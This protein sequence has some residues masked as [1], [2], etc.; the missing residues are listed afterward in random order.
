MKCLSEYLE[1]YSKTKPESTF[2]VHK[3]GTYTYYQI[4][5]AVN[6]LC[7]LIQEL[8]VE[9][10]LS[11]GIFLTGSPEFVVALYSALRFRA[12]VIIF[13]PNLTYQELAKLLG[14]S[15][16]DIL[17]FNTD[18]LEKVEKASFLSKHNFGRIIF[19]TPGDARF[20]LQNMIS[21]ERDFSS[22]RNIDTENNS[23]TIFTKKQK[24]KRLGISY[25]QKN[26]ISAIEAFS[27][28]LRYLPDKIFINSYP[29]NTTKGCILILNTCLYTGGKLIISTT[30][31]TN[32][33]KKHLIKEKVSILITD[34]AYF[35]GLTEEIDFENDDLGS[36]ELVLINGTYPNIENFKRW[37]KTYGCV[38]LE[39][40]GIPETSEV[41]SWNLS[42][43]ER[44]PGSIGLPLGCNQVKI[45]DEYGAEVESGNAGLLAIKGDNIVK[46]Y[47]DHPLELER[48]WLITDYVA[49]RDENGFIY[50]KAQ[51]KDLINRFGYRI[52]PEEIETMVREIPEVKDVAAV[53]LDSENGNQKLKICVV[54]DNGSKVNSAEIEDAINERLPVYLQPDYIELLKCIPKDEYGNVL[55]YKLTK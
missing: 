29:L 5:N 3:S 30:N 45:V 44:T 15:K 9:Q 34:G 31:R 26:I 55:R 11:I 8:P 1:F 54:L 47:F 21:N 12:N 50:I 52:L 22:S 49:V 32:Q 6:N 18:L 46:G 2:L 16:P 43:A 36:L 40:F 53:G 35:N 39:G 17:I 42:K 13:P 48:G 20:S 25:T 14:L 41:C 24:Q 51:K 37:E 38:I 23:I 4:N 28:I 7:S 19:N 10:K 33:I 27:T